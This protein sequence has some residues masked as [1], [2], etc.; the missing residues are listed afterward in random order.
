[1]TLMNEDDEVVISEDIT[2]NTKTGVAKYKGVPLS[3][4]QPDVSEGIYTVNKEEYMVHS[5]AIAWSDY[6]ASPTRPKTWDD[7]EREAD[8][9]YKIKDLEAPATEAQI[10]YLTTLVHQHSDMG[11]EVV[12]LWKL[13]G[14]LTKGF[15]STMIEDLKSQPKLRTTMPPYRDGSAVEL[16]F[17]RTAAGEFYEVVL[18]K[19]KQRRY[20]KILKRNLEPGKNATWSWEYRKGA[21]SALKGLVP[22]SIGEAGEWG[23]ANS[24]CIICLRPLTD[25]DSIKKGIGPS[26]ARRL[27]T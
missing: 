27:K 20:A 13:S 17:Y 15:A 6:E 18:T 7:I 16:G 21:L 9:K 14:S 2:F 4:W 22:L 24:R 3:T 23:K 26:C 10:N 11:T 19:D 12:D 5:P 1:M 25:E 8:A